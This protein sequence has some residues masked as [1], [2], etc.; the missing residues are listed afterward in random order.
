MCGIFE[1]LSARIL[2]RI[3]FSF[4]L[5][6]FMYSL[7]MEFVEYIIEDNILLIKYPFFN[8]KS[9]NLDNLLGF[10]FYTWRETRLYLFFKNNTEVNIPYTNN[11]HKVY[12]L[13]ITDEW[14][15]ILEEKIIEKIKNTGLNFRMNIK[16]E[17]IFK[18]N[19]LEIVENGKLMEKYSYN[20][21]IKKIHI[22]DPFYSHDLEIMFFNEKTIRLSKWELKESTGLL[23]FLANN[24]KC[25]NGT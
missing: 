20:K 25:P 17:I 18:V 1:T 10:H 23:F 4:L 24:I 21:D 9:Y 13:K 15:R 14:G 16:E 19:H 2:A 6:C 11:E 7:Y 22:P 8:V 12:L 3:T 5:L